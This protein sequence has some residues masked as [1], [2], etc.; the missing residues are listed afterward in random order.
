[1][2][3]AEGE[4]LQNY[5]SRYFCRLVEFRVAAGF[6]LR[7]LQS[8]CARLFMTQ[9]SRNIV[10]AYVNEA[11]KFKFTANNISSLRENVARIVYFEN[12]SKH[13]FSNTIVM[14]VLDVIFFRDCWLKIKTK[15]HRRKTQ[16]TGKIFLHHFWKLKF[17]CSTPIDCLSQ[18]HPS[19]VFSQRHETL[20]LFH[21]FC[22]ASRIFSDAFTPPRTH[23]RYLAGGINIFV[24]VNRVRCSLPRNLGNSLTLGQSQ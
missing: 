16:Y 7:S 18:H 12:M 10:P 23:T 13:F 15:A 19:P 5:S 4:Q 20:I 8:V 14:K 24:P 17:C 22:L 9:C 3:M 6:H 11:T 2:R 21:L 1:M